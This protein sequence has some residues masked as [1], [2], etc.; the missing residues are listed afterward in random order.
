M[1]INKERGVENN[2]VSQIEEQSENK[3]FI[4]DFQSRKNKKISN[5]QCSE[6]MQRVIGPGNR[7]MSSKRCYKLEK[8]IS[9]HQ[10]KYEHGSIH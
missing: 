4:S 6:W 3:S 10:D 5:P 7:H 9:P 8:H 2:S 1:D